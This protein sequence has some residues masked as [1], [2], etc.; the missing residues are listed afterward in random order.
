MAQQDYSKVSLL[1]EQGSPTLTSNKAT[2]NLRRPAND[3]L[4]SEWKPSCLR[5]EVENPANT[6]SSSGSLSHL[7]S[8]NLRNPDNMRAN[9]TADGNKTSLFAARSSTENHAPKGQ[10]AMDKLKNISKLRRIS[11]GAADGEMK[12]AMNR[13]SVCHPISMVQTESNRLRGCSAAQ[14][15]L[16]RISRRFLRHLNRLEAGYA[17]PLRR[18]PILE[19]ASVCMT[20]R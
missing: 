14:E 13:L 19:T 20:L 17:F 4:T 16:R 15:L 10:T 7:A 18:I 5:N 2:G 1:S 9:P 12:N 3:S 6:G 8:D 11:L